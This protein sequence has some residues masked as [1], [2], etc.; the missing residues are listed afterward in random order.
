MSGEPDIKGEFP[1]AELVKRQQRLR[2]ARGRPLKGVRR[3]PIT[4]YLTAAE[5]EMLGRLQVELQRYFAVN[6]SEVVGVAI[7]L[8]SA[9]VDSAV[10]QNAL[11]T[12]DL[13][14]FHAWTL[15]LADFIKLQNQKKSQ[16][17]KPGPKD[18]AQP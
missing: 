9:V 3:D 6:R 13:D 12:N 18:T 16:K 1:F 8:L 4:V 17:K 5:R 15:Q 11:S 14:T 10:E 2:R 7:G